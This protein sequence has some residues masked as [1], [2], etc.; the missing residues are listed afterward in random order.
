M[1]RLVPGASA[2]LLFAGL[3]TVLWAPPLLAVRNFEEIIA[4]SLS[5]E[6][7]YLAFNAVDYLN[8]DD[9]KTPVQHFWAMSIQAQ[10]Y[11]IWIL[12]AALVLLI[13][14][15]FA[16][17]A[18]KTMMVVLFTLF[19]VSLGLSIWQTAVAQPF[20]YFVP[21]TRMWEFAVGGFLAILGSRIQ[22]KGTAAAAAS[23]LAMVVLVLTGAVLPVEGGFPGIIAAVPVLAAAAILVSTREDE[24]WWAGTRL[25]SWKPLVWLGSMACGI[26]LWHWPLLV[27]Y[28]YWRGLDAQPG[29]LAGPA[30]IIGAIVLAYLTKLL[31]EN[32]VQRGWPVGGLRRPAIA[33]GIVVAWCIAAA[34][35]TAGLINDN[36][37]RQMIE[38]YEPP[39]AEVAA[40]WGCQEFTQE[41][42]ACDDV[43]KDEPVVPARQDIQGD[44]RWA[45]D[46][47]GLMNDKQLLTCEFG[48][49]DADVRVALMGNSHAAVMLPDFA[50]LAEERGWHLT[51][52]VAQNCVWMATLDSDDCGSRIQ[53]QR[54]LLTEDP[55]DVV[56]LLG[57]AGQGEKPDTTPIVEARFLELLE[58]GSEVIV[59]EDNPRMSYGEES[60]LYEVSDSRLRAGE[61]DT[62]VEVGYDYVDPYWEVVKQHDEVVRIGTR[63]FYCREGVCPLVIGNVIVYGD[64]HHITATYGVTAWP[65]IAERIE[66]ES[67]VL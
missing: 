15:V 64:R 33:T 38:V 65:A 55:F 47:V 36:N 43:I 37:R 28:R 49:E 26:C 62:T 1:R 29:M 4:S 61:C 63:D 24:K 50:A 12:I 30:I 17:N 32:P 58:T 11:V 9:P 3:I 2:V 5:F 67:D 21:W 54:R 35:P 44:H 6:N 40:C 53:E 45:Y 42:G 10:F 27:L 46:C 51:T 14:K 66:A 20:A 25:L 19:V 18:R 52:M 34:V 60:C 57:N 16:A 56:V 22:L 13:V 39:T 41:S 7:L 8:A 31:L 48:P 59:L 23:L